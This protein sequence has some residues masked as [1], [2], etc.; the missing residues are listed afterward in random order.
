MIRQQPLRRVQGHRESYR[1]RGRERS[2]GWAAIRSTAAQGRTMPSSARTCCA[3]GRGEGA[4]KTGR[5]TLL[6]VRP[7]RQRIAG[8]GGLVSQEAASASSGPSQTAE[9]R[10][11][12]SNRPPPSTSPLST[13]PGA[14]PYD[15]A[16]TALRNMVQVDGLRGGDEDQ[17]PPH[18]QH[19]RPLH[20]H[21]GGGHQ[22]AITR[23]AAY[24]AT[25]R[26]SATSG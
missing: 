12:R 13:A 15:C 2:A 19:L 3:S 26:P 11:Y 23:T 16:E 18:A 24:V 4:R 1:A 22:G 14:R 20:H 9:G 17:R 7:G 25:F 6:A 21:V 5:S 8:L 10:P